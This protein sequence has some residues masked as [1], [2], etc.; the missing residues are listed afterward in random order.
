[1]ISTHNNCRA[2]E[3]QWHRYIKIQQA[4]KHISRQTFWQVIKQEQFILS[5]FWRRVSTL[6]MYKMKRKTICAH[7]HLTSSRKFS[8]FPRLDNLQVE[9][10]GNITQRND[11]QNLDDFYFVSISAAKLSTLSC[12][13]LH[14]LW[15]SEHW[16]ML[17]IHQPPTESTNPQD[18]LFIHKKQQ[19][20]MTHLLYNHLF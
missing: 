8:A 19:S 9:P 20:I 14:T 12:L 17:S 3:T 16:V 10:N 4:K 5:T 7:N 13:F 6:K 18:R 2:L 11:G 1:M 15:I